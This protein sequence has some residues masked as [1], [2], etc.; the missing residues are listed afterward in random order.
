[1]SSQ[2]IECRFHYDYFLPKYPSAK[3]LFTDT[4]SLYYHIESDDIEQELFQDKDRF[5][6][7]DYATTSPYFD[8]SN[9][10]VIGKFKCETKGMP[11]I[12]FVGLRPKMYSYLYQNSPKPEATIIEKHRVKGIASAASRALKHY[13]YK[14]QLDTPHENFIENRRLGSKLHQIYA[15]SCEKR[16]LCSFDDKR[17]LLADN[18]HSLAYGHYSITSQVHRDE[19]INSGGEQVMS[20][21]EARDRGLIWWRRKGAFARLGLT[22]PE[23]NETNQDLLSKGVDAIQTNMFEKEVCASDRVNE[24]VKLIEPPTITA[25][26]TSDEECTNFEGG[27]PQPRSQTPAKQKNR[28]PKAAKPKSAK[29]DSTLCV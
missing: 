9:K 2:C 24:E 1:M 6:Y 12:E 4:D 21:Q 8:G 22:E 16:G 20:M 23:W 3:L 26:S 25:N 27:A 19:I 13:D 15:I 10:K 17:F 18:I 11:I 5:D 28:R 29:A 14:E 7:S